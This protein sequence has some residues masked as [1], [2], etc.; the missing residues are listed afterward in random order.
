MTPPSH[1]LLA[2]TYPVLTEVKTFFTNSGMSSGTRLARGDF[3][4]DG[5]CRTAQGIRH[6]HKHAAKMMQETDQEM[7]P[8][9]DDII[10]A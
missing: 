6:M 4:G 2:A 1:H 5:D 10:V 8:L 7:A 9:P 3:L